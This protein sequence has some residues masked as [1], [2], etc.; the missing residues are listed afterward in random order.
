MKKIQITNGYTL[1]IADKAFAAAEEDYRRESG[2][3]DV[4]S[5]EAILECTTR[6][7]S[8][9]SLVRGCKYTVHVLAR[10]EGYAKT[11]K[12]GRNDIM[13]VVKVTCVSS[14]ECKVDGVEA[15]RVVLH[16]GE[17]ISDCVKT[18]GAATRGAHIA[19]FIGRERDADC[20]C[21]IK[22][23]PTLGYQDNKNASK[24]VWERFLE[25]IFDF[26]V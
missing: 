14:K 13:T 16:P 3:M 1:K 15:S 7:L 24:L 19:R 22:D 4:C 10:G 20:P 26:T 6:L 5:F 9:K 11:C 8:V 25:A 2:K 21:W 23:V 12:Y 17:S 18:F